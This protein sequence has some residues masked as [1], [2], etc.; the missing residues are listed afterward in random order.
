MST[1]AVLLSA[2]AVDV[3]ESAVAFVDCVEAGVSFELSCFLFLPRLK[4]PFSN[5]LTLSTVSGAAG[6]KV[7]SKL[8][9]R[10]PDEFH[11]NLRTPGI[12]TGAYS[13]SS[14]MKRTIRYC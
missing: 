12:M 7:V 8:Q 2:S 5:R 6:V 1:A 3:L 13:E 14:L 9:R 10:A 4:I 11:A